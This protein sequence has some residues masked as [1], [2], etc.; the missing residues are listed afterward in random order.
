MRILKKRRRRERS[1]D[2]NRLQPN[3][4]PLD[5]TLDIL[6]RLPAKSIVRY[7]CVSKLWS[8]SIK[9]PSFINSFTARSTS[10]SPTLLV[11]ISSGSRKYVFSF[12]QHHIP[13]GSICSP[14]YSYQIT[15][16]DHSRSDSIHGLI[17]TSLLKIWNPTLRQFLALPH[18]D[19]CSLSRNGSYNSD[20]SSYLGYDPL[21]GKHKVLFMSTIECT[22]QPRV[23]T[24]GA[25]ES[26]RIITKGRCPMHRPCGDGRCFNGILYYIAC[27]LDDSHCI[28]M[29][30][31]VKS[32]Y[33]NIINY[34]EGR[35]CSPFHMISYEGRLALVTY[36]H[37][38]D[39]VE[40]DILKDANGHIWRRERYVLH[41]PY[42]SIRRDLIRFVGTT[43]VGEF[44]FAPYVINEAFYIIYFDPRRNSTRKVL[45]GR[46]SD[47]FRR[48]CGFDSNDYF[49]MEVYPNHI[50]SLFSL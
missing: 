47:E 35:F 40:L 8:S 49:S 29:S 24:L 26:W 28:I 19:K 23:L 48:R 50:E 33:F 45:F 5:L 9:L 3:H 32:E 25:Q 12:P 30:F 41:L 21:E 39:Y 17:L 2:D 1:R 37:P 20:L 7:Q 18:P 46:N 27:L 31:D 36:D 34:P 6:S 22:D 44:V 10:R 15:N 11:T 42:E 38:Y 14:F 16:L 4:I 43:D 13:D